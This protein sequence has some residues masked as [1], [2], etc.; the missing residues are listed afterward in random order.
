MWGCGN[1]CRGLCTWRLGDLG[2]SVGF[3]NFE[4]LPIV[5]ANGPSGMPGEWKD[6]GHR[7]MRWMMIGLTVLIAGI[8]MIAVGNAI[9]PGATAAG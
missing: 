9:M 5:V 4:S 6:A 3:A 1:C 7:S 2:T 8:V